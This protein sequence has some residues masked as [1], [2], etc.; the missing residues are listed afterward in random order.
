MMTMSYIVTGASG[1][2]GSNLVRA[3]N[4]L[5]EKAIIAVDDGKKG[6]RN[7]ADCTIADYL[8]KREFIERFANGAFDGGIKALIHQGASTDTLENDWHSLMVNNYHY[9]VILLEHCQKAHIPFL[10]ASSTSV[11][12]A[13][14]VFRESP[15]WEA[16]LNPY[17]YSK[18]LFDQHVRQ[19][20][21]RFRSQVVGL[22]Y[23]NVYGPG[24]QHKGRMASVAFHLFHHYRR[25]GR[26]K[27]FQGCDGYG[28][29]MQRRDF[30]H[31]SEVVKVTFFF[32]DHPEQ[33]DI[34]NV[35]TGQSRTFNDVAAA[36]VNACRAHEGEAPLTLEEIRAKGIIE[37]IP[38][39]EEL[40]GRYQSYTQADISKLRRAGYSDLFLTVEA[41]VPLYVKDLLADEREDR[42]V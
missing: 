41:G 23:F 36:V 21:G 14:T 26:V 22:R 17:G 16:P 32:L 42:S 28:D 7:L 6:M 33:S 29:G 30:I 34:F 8:D 18:F 19:N 13:G 31:V 2:I 1:F 40:R 4:A 9:S 25:E 20:W 11:Y 12:G 5:G 15:E 37:Y 10:Y 3:L 35:G 38:F 39:P 24:E 27:L